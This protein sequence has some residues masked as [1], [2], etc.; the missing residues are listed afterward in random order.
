MYERYNSN[1][2][3]LFKGKRERSKQYLIEA[4]KKD[5]YGPTKELLNAP[6]KAWPYISE[7]IR[8]NLKGFF[9]AVLRIPPDERTESFLTD[10][11]HHTYISLIREGHITMVELDRYRKEEH[12]LNYGSIYSDFL[13]GDVTRAFKLKFWNHI[14]SLTGLA[15]R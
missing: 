6:E 2:T 13:S 4:N 11:G 12:P 5:P 7:I 1:P 10:M 3:A 9:L 8:S 14:M 15:K